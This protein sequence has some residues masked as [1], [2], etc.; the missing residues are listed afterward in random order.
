MTNS[1]FDLYTG[2][3]PKPRY[4]H[5][6]FAN[7]G[8]RRERFIYFIFLSA[9]VHIAL[10]GSLL[11]YRGLGVGSINRIERADDFQAFREAISDLGAMPDNPE[12]LAGMLSTVTDEDFKKGFQRAPELDDRLTSKERAAIL[13]ALV[14]NSPVRA[15]NGIDPGPEVN[16]TLE[17][18]FDEL[19]SRSEFR[20]P[21]GSKYLRFGS[22][23]GK[24]AKYYRLSRESEQGLLSHKNSGKISQPV[25]TSGA[26]N[27]RSDNG[28]LKVPSEYYFRQPPYE[29]ILAIGA[30]LYYF[31]TGFPAIE[32]PTEKVSGKPSSTESDRGI[33]LNETENRPGLTLVFIR[34]AKPEGESQAG[35]SPA[36]ISLAM[37]SINQILDGLNEYPDETQFELFR[38]DYLEKYDADNPLLASLAKD[39]IYKNLGTVFVLTDPL[40]TGFDFLEGI[41]LRKLTMDG[42]VSYCLNNPRAKTSV[43]ILFCL[44][45]YYDFERR[46][47]S[48]LYEAI[49][50]A[51]QVLADPSY[52][53]DVFDLR[54]KAFVLQQVH[55]ELENEIQAGGYSSIEAVLQRYR[56]QQA[57]IYNFL[58]SMEGDIKDKALYSLGAL[59]WD[60]TRVD[61]AIKTWKEV[62]PDYSESP[63]PKIR[64]FIAVDEP[65]ILEDNIARVLDD[66]ARAN[67]HDMA[68]RLGRFHKWGTGRQ[69]TRQ[70]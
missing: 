3:T 35:S 45:A 19:G 49:E 38:R 4:F 59:Y 37:N 53:L 32:L 69:Q 23:V 31:V 34:D 41:Y 68:E 56:A 7:L 48:R 65:G 50:V 55:H 63:F 51:E 67:R 58:R 14:S 64:G 13:K 22:S 40:S 39:F 27:V 21:D 62:S 43:E 33:S 18:I 30:R 28:I 24:P 47:L 44:A 17:D 11:I 52:Q 61:M 2:L 54:A 20:G 60:E 6:F 9:F 16:F 25:V 29:Q 57:G 5:R 42:F 36:P 70:N 10:L 8:R 66:E 1:P 46:S 12:V 15:G 26:V